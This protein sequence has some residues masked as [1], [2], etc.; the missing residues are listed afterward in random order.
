MTKKTID[1][2]TRSL[3]KIGKIS[4]HNLGLRPLHTDFINNDESQGYHVTFVSG[5]DD[6]TNG[7]KPKQLKDFTDI[8]LA[9][10]VANNPGNAEAF[11]MWVKRNVL[12]DTMSRWGH[13]KS[14]ISGRVT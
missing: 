5:S 4:Q 13:F 9:E 12:Q 6:P 7:P 11:R 14:I 10:E 3:M 2:Q 8:E 1:F